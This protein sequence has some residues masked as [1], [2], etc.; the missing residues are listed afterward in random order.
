MAFGLGFS[1]N[2]VYWASLTVE[3]SSSAGRNDVFFG[4][5]GAD[6]HHHSWLKWCG[7]DLIELGA[8]LKDPSLI[9]RPP[10]NVTASLSTETLLRFRAVYDPT[11]QCVTTEI[12]DTFSGSAVS[13]APSESARTDSRRGVPMIPVAVPTETRVIEGEL[14]YCRI[15]PG[16]FSTALSTETA[17]V[18]LSSDSSVGIA[19]L[20]THRSTG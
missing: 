1:W 2:G 19:L 8:R 20:I 3:Q 7:D 14:A 16:W 9:E 18:P 17:Y 6:S 15:P 5:V 4:P 10:S 12:A 11:R 13:A